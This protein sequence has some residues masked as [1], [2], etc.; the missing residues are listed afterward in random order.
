MFIVAVKL[1][2]LRGLITSRNRIY[3]ILNSLLYGCYR[4]LQIFLHS[5]VI[6]TLENLVSVL[7]LYI[8]GCMTVSTD[9]LCY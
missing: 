3:K 6:A 7:K 1:L 5:S 9:I 8:D 4:S 2:V